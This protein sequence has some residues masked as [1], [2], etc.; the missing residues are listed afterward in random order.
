MKTMCGHLLDE[1]LMSIH[2]FSLWVLLLLLLLLLELM[3]LLD[4]LYKQH[5]FH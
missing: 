2:W 1:T 3:L 5:K 4:S